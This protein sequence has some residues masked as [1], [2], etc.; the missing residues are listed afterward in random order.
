VTRLTGWSARAA[1][2]RAAEFGAI[3]FSPARWSTD[4]IV[5]ALGALVLAISVF[6]PWFQATVQ[7]MRTSM[8]GRL[9]SPKGT[10]SGIAL[11]HY[12][13]AVVALALLEFAV[14]AARYLPRPRQPALPGYRQFLIVASALNCVVVVGSLAVKP[15][16]WRGVKMYPPFHLVV[17]WGYGSAVALVAALGT[18][19]AAIVAYRDRAVRLP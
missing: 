10:I 7:I 12:L 11:H 4:D 8:Q 9:M 6:F 3:W 14:L 19:V 1:R 13:W 16:N 2:R 5:T 15:D 18:L 17:G